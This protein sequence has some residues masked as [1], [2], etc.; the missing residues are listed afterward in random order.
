MIPKARKIFSF[1]CLGLVAFAMI[2]YGEA[3]KTDPYAPVYTKPLSAEPLKGV[4]SRALEFPFKLIKWPM[5]QGIIFTE[6]H[7]LDKKTKWI[8]EESLKQGVKPLFGFTDL[9]AL[10]FFGAELNLLTLA[11]QKEK[12]P[13]LF[14][15]TTLLYCPSVFFSVGS[16]IGAQKIAETGFHTKGVFNYDL[17]QKE[18]FYG[19]GPH[20]S[21]GDGSSYRME[22]TKV[23]ARAGYEFSPT[24]DLEGG[25][26]YRKVNILNRAHDG[27]GDIRTIFPGQN[28][29]G[30]GGDAL[31]DYSL[32]L[33]R[34][35]RDSKDEATKGSYQKLLFQF[36]DSAKGSSASYFKYQIDAAK[37]F[38]LASP[39][40]ILVARLFAEHNQKIDHGDVPFYDMAKL[41]G[42][43]ANIRDSETARAFVYNRFYG[44]SALLLNLEYRY[45]VMEYKEFKLKTA[46]FND[47]GEVF[48][49]IHQFRLAD[50]RESYGVGFYLSYARNTLLNFSVAH[51]NEG[52]RFYVK[53]K[54]A[55]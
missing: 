26:D 34:D 23:G 55:F 36:T 6:N 47:L 31:L 42:A 2:G 9:S 30:I 53:N 35:T 13:D 29:P 25:F 28:I 41:G 40:R 27:K 8:Y 46:V 44:E 18:P 19:I 48:G 43:G 22:T 45:T 37:Y 33:G 1:L 38:R 15:T 49:K 3:K 16:E 14:A 20:T 52:T 39:R 50:L 4:F 24:L 11:R 17:Q 32:A 12:Y 5:D 51:G 7:R 10:P 21:R 54:L